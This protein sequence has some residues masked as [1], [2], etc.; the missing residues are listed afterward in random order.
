MPRISPQQNLRSR[1]L[2]VKYPIAIP[3]L[4]FL[5]IM[6]ADVLSV[7]ALENRA[8]R[9][10]RALMERMAEAKSS[11]L[12]RNASIEA[13]Y[14]RAGGMLFA[15]RG[16]VERAAFKEFVEGLDLATD[17]HEQGSFGWAAKEE[18]F[19]SFEIK[20]YLSKSSIA[21]RSEGQELGKN[22][23]V[24]AAMEE[25]AKSKQPVV[26][27]SFRAIENDADAAPSFVFVMPVFGG[28][29]D[30]SV[31]QGY[32]F[33]EFRVQDFYDAAALTLDGGI[34][35]QIASYGAALYDGD[36]HPRNRVAGRT[37]QSEPARFVDHQIILANRPLT[38]RVSSGEQPVL[39]PL[40]LAT[41][42]FGLV[43]ATLMG[44]LM[45]MLAVQAVEDQNA[46][47][48]YAEQNSIRNSLT[49]ELNHR[50]KNTLANVLS[51]ITLTRRRAIDLDEFADG[52]EGRVRALS[53]THDLLTN[54]EWGEIPVHGVVEA[55]LAA[56][57][58]ANDGDRQQANQIIKS[59][60]KI[61]LA[62]KDA[63]SLGMALHELVTNASRFGALSTAEGT[64][65]ITWN[66]VRDD[67]IEFRWAEEGGPPILSKPR[68]K[69]GLELIE[70]VTAHEL[71]SPVDLTFDEAGLR[72][73]FIVPARIPT[74]F[75][76]RAQK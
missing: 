68:S 62:P 54:A 63:L 20:Y 61:S 17:Y 38:L 37:M 32:L 28:S 44:L 7:V 10:E 51:L 59:G 30:K 66:L 70:K 8:A 71:R 14:L 27:K 25:A 52:I 56:F 57:E 2:L 18:S 13:S 53:A 60:P 47:E 45:R 67:R 49:R 26:S 64:V 39:T 5:L 35:E 72:C 24:R 12:E 48:R 74:E 4:I 15:A 3:I 34:R 19:P 55:E 69:F 65:K 31:L 33:S 21:P 29:S 6:L 50:V 1:K 76:M 16:R 58:R 11:A 36:A 42:A 40:S 73:T 75:S 46:L 43:A 41:L 23:A 22:T 9:D